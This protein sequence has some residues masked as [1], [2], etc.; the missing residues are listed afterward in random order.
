[1][2]ET[3][4]ETAQCLWAAFQAVIQELLCAST[5]WPLKGM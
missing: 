2:S 1:M 3:P 4:E 5:L